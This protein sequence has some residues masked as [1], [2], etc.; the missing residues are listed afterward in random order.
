VNQSIAH[1]EVPPVA[2][3][4]SDSKATEK[5]AFKKLPASIAVTNHAFLKST[6]RN[7]PRPARYASTSRAFV[8]DGNENNS[9]ALPSDV[10]GIAPA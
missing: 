8:A 4:E 3:T 7:P 1:S 5:G 10:G 2:L 6:T 9:N